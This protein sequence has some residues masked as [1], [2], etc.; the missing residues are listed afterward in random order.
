MSST[1]EI[2]DRHMATFGK[3]DIAG[4]L[5]DYAPD[6]VMF[7]PQGARQGQ[8]A[9]R[10]VFEQLFEEWAKP[11]VAFTLN[12]RIVDGNHAYIFWNAET[13]DNRYEGATDAFVIADGKI[14]AHFFAGKITPKGLVS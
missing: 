10:G 14:V 2:L 9:L 1:N 5:A 3:Q 7:T 8:Q 13:A 4:V 6:A 11:G 12:Q